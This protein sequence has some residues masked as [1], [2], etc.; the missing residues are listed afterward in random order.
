MPWNISLLTTIYH[1]LTFNIFFPEASEPSGNAN[2]I[3]IVPMVAEYVCC[4]VKVLSLFWHVLYNLRK[5]CHFTVDAFFSIAFFLLEIVCSSST[6]RTQIFAYTPIVRVYPFTSKVSIELR[7]KH[8]RAKRAAHTKNQG[9][10][11]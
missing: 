11:K 1:L 2:N 6:K 8:I 9:R 5:N 10:K 7:N 3:S 4:F